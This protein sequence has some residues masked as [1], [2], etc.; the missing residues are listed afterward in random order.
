MGLDMYLSAE[1][2]NGGGY[3]FHRKDRDGTPCSS[4]ETEA[5]DK[6]ITTVGYDSYEAFRDQYPD[7]D[8]LEVNIQV[9]YW[10]KANAI[11]AWFVREVQDG[12][13]ECQRS[14]V[15]REKLEEL[16]QLCRTILDTVVKG[17]P[18]EQPDVFGGTYDEYPDLTLDVDLANE[19]LPPQSGFF[20]G[21]TNID[22]WYV[23][24]LENTVRQLDVVLS[25]PVLRDGDFR[26]QS[27]W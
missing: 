3:T 13:D 8:S 25:D 15:S 21:D 12:V 22:Q 11:H 20:F 23:S 10:R 2:Y 4:P 18:V 5:F 17:D 19:L 6:I 24:D 14:Y 9:A 27:S 1:I 16:R 26:Y 7:G